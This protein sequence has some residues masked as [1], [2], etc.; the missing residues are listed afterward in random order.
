MV[1]FGIIGTNKITETML[2]AAQHVEGFYL[3]AV[4]SRT[5][6]N[7]NTFANKHDVHH[8][9]T[10]LEELAESK[11]IEAVY[12][13]S[14]NSFHVKHAILMMDHGKH[15][16]CEKPLASNSD[17][18]QKM[19][20]AAKRNG[21]S[22]MEAMKTTHLPNFKQIQKYI[23]QIGTIR[24]YVVQFS[25][26]S[27]RYDAYRR[28]EIL[29][30][31]NPK[32]SNGSLM[33]LGVYGLYPMITLFGA[34]SKVQAN[35]IMLSSGV[36][37]EGTVLASYS[38]MEGVVSH[39]KISTSYAPCEIQGEDGTIVFNHMGEPTDVTLYLKD[40]SKKDISAETS[41]PPMAY[42]VQEFINLVHEGKQE[43]SVNTWE[44]SLQTS[45]VTEEARKQVGLIYEADH[46]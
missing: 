23:P 37:G 17:E 27:S 45:K 43:S 14:P 33:D 28:G 10:N 32:F 39:S 26:Y 42:E 29:N 12:I 40:G 38:E 15:V 18:V 8:T 7:A 3:N 24:R 11:E 36:D 25:K 31:F 13:A 9:Y 22:F 35:A 34:P 19:I 44:R 16:L 30:A 1:R 4:Y 2:H 41:L 21:V 20:E 46:Q 5:E 6:E